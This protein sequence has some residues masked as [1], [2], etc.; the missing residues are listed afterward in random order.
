MHTEILQ[1]KRPMPYNGIAYILYKVLACRPG[2]AFIP[3][4]LSLATWMYTKC[5]QA[6]AIFNS[7]FYKLDLQKFDKSVSCDYK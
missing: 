4:R 1:D 7:T 2:Y 3:I 6:L 5:V